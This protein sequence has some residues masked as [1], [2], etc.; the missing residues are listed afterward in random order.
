MED[1]GKANYMKTGEEILIKDV[2]RGKPRVKQGTL[3]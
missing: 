1:V 2:V 3:F